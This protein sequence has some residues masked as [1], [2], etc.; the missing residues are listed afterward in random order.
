MVDSD[1]M[2]Y[3]ALDSSTVRSRNKQT[4]ARCGRIRCL[5]PNAIIVWAAAFPPTVWAAGCMKDYAFDNLA[6]DM[7]SIQTQAW[8]AK[9]RELLQTFSAE[10]PL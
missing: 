5:N 7:E 6:E 9:V 3:S 1:C 8:P 2:P 10:E 4:R